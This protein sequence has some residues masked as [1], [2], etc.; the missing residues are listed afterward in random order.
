VWFGESLPPQAWAAAERAAQACDC[1]LSIGTS[2][3]VYPAAGLIDQALAAGA[4]LLEINPE[5]TA[6]TAHAAISLRGKS[7]ELLPRLVHASW[8]DPKQKRG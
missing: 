7:G 3:Q 1:F 6:Y 8:P 4:A 5:P 2:A